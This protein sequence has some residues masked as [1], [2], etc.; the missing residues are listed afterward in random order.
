[1]YYVYVNECTVQYETYQAQQQLN[2]QYCPHPLLLG[3]LNSGD[4]LGNHRQHF[5]VNSIELIETSPRPRA[6]QTLEELAHSHEV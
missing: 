6:S 4:L 5:N 3:N 2:C 1:M